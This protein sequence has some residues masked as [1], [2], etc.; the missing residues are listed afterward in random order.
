MSADRPHCEAPQ[1]CA[2]KGSGHCRRCCG[3]AA[4][5]A[6]HSD[7]AGVARLGVKARAL[8]EALNRD[9]AVV[10]KRT[11]TTNRLRTAKTAE[12]VRIP[13]SLV[14]EYRALLRKE[15]T[16]EQAVGVLRRS[17]REAFG[18]GRARGA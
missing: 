8:A 17:Y 5:A 13:V 16:S 6:L 15:L 4:A 10:A 1:A 2:A 18:A 7:P 14:G 9:P 12:R 3:R 11:A